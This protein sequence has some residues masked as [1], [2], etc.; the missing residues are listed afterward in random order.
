MFMQVISTMKQWHMTSDTNT[1]QPRMLYKQP[2]LLPLDQAVFSA[3][4]KPGFF[5]HKLL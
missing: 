3:G 5:M 1:S 4:R 2:D